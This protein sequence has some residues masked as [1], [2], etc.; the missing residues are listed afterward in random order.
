MSSPDRRKVLGAA[1]RL[2]AVALAAASAAGCGFQP[3]YGDRPQAGNPSLRDALSAIR[4]NQIDAANGTAEARIA[5]ELRNQLLFALT[6]GS[7]TAPPTHELTI[8]MKS[9]SSAIITDPTSQRF[10]VENFGLDVSYVLKEIATD[11]PVVRSTTFAR[12]T[13]DTPGGEQRFV[14]ARGLRSA[15][16]RAAKV[17]AEHIR[18]R[19]ASYFVAGT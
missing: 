10:I 15:E 9:D 8:A 13:Y 2:T 5:V 18:N 12:V 16:D 17:I 11:K 4:I 7:G 6:G 3:L 1:M 19:L 14:R